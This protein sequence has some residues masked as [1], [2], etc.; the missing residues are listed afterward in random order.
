MRAGN[1]RH[2]ISVETNTISVDANG[3]RTESWATF[4]T[5][6][7]SIETGN[8]REFFAAKQTIADLTHTIRMRYVAALAPDMRIKYVDKKNADATRYFNIRAILNPDERNEMLTLQ[9][10][11]VII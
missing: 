5:C 8:G 2:S 4:L 6:W 11:E 7:A 3:D 9:A 10:T 1:L